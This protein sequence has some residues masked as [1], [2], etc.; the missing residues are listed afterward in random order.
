L[1]TVYLYISQVYHSNLTMKK[2]IV[3]T[4]IAFCA[5]QAYSQVFKKHNVTISFTC[6]LQNILNTNDGINNVAAYQCVT[7]DDFI[8]MYRLTTIMFAYPI[9]DFNTY[10]ES[11]KDEYSAQGT[12][13]E[14][15]LGGKRAVQVKEDIVVQGIKLTQYSIATLHKN[16]SITIVYVTN[17][18]ENINLGR[19]KNSVTLN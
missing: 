1:A 18:T 10:I 5:T 6:S 11:L 3:L 14:T 9:T 19:Y 8:D 12:V 16:Q 13:K 7:E 15:T 17:R 2:I 4:L